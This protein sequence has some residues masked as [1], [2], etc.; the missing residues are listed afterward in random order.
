MANEVDGN[1]FRE[2]VFVRNDDTTTIKA[3]V[4]EWSERNGGGLSVQLSNGNESVLISFDDWQT[5]VGCVNVE[6]NRLQ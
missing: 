1:N 2:P 5:L 4:V 3:R 6:L